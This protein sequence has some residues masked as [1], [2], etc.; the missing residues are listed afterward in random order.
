MEPYVMT[1]P[2]EYSRE[3]GYNELIIGTPQIRKRL[4]HVGG[5]DFLFLDEVWF[6]VHRAI[7]RGS[8]GK[9]INNLIGI[10]RELEVSGVRSEITQENME[11]IEAQS[12]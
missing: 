4:N 5:L 2:S 11:L 6:N 12:N 8:H 10:D 9:W 3:I 1:L 7:N